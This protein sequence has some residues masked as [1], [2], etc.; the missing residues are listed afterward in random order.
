[1]SMIRDKLSFISY[2]SNADGLKAQSPL[3]PAYLRDNA[4]RL[5]FSTHR[6]R[7]SKKVKSRKIIQTS[8]LGF[9]S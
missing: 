7:N 4:G 9:W 2:K 5:Q 1:M 8:I 3:R 6:S